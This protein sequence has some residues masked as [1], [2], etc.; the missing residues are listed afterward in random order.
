MSTKNFSIK[1]DPMIQCPCCKRGDFTLG[2]YILLQSIRTDL[3][4][5][6]TVTAGARC[7]KHQVNIYE[8]LG[9]PPVKKSDHLMN[10]DEECNGAD[11]VV[12]GMTPKEVYTYLIS[13]P[14]ANLLA[15]GLYSWG[16]HLGLRGKPARW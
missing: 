5:V 10:D 11:L 8:D 12:P 13:R 16:I 1:T 15:I 7:W 6:I 3:D 2:M 4:R 14:D 9:L